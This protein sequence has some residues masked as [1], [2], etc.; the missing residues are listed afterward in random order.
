MKR[1]LTAAAWNKLDAAIQGLY[2]KVDGKDGAPE[3]YMLDIEDDDDDDETHP[4]V[5]AK[6]REKEARKQAEAD[7][8][9][10]KDEL[11]ALKKAREDADDEGARGKGD[12]KALEE[13]WKKKYD[14]RE[15]ELLETIAQRD[16]NLRKLLIDSQA[17]A[18]ARE[19]STTPKAMSRLIKDRLTIEI[20][21]GESVVRV[22]DNN[23][24]PSATTLAELKKEIMSDKDLAGMIIGSK[25]S[26]GGA[27]GGGGAGGGAFKIEDYRN[28]DKSINWS[29]VAADD[30]TTPGVLKQVK[31]AIGQGPASAT[32]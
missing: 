30:K 17:D 25:A 16:G 11:K 24:K 31:A 18:L 19:I 23:G 28:E 5:R 9:A 8:K 21:D 13:S 7:L 10:A 3:N 14:T 29:K 32:E 1:K 2:K 22:L 6:N 20:V 4:A 27:S 12:V 26:G 15:K